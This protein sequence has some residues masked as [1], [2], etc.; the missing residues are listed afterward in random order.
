[1]FGTRFVKQ[2]WLMLLMVFA[3]GWSGVSVAST[4]TMHLILPAETTTHTIPM[5]A[6]HEFLDSAH[7]SQ[8][9][10]SSHCDSGIA[11]HQ[12]CLD[13]GYS[14][15]QS[16]ITGLNMHPPELHS[17]NIQFA[18]KTALPIYSAQHLAGYWQEILRPPKA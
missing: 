10:A 4:K 1:M 7:E 8:A 6:N 5:T 18:E 11:T 13:C 15:C 16:L 12:D 9:F 14:A 2:L 17:F 3:I